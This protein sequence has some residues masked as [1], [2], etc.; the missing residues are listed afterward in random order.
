LIYGWLEFNMLLQQEV[1]L[2]PL[3]C[4]S[5]PANFLAQNSA[6][7]SCQRS[8]YCRHLVCVTTRKLGLLKQF[9]IQF[10]SLRTAST[11]RPS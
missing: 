11:C 7:H 1:V 4:I 8:R 3:E 6:S 10:F 2:R 9:F 5:N